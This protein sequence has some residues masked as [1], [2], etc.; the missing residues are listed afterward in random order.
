MKYFGVVNLRKYLVDTEEDK[1]K[2]D[3]TRVSTCIVIF[4]SEVVLSH[5]GRRETRLNSICV[6]LTF[7]RFIGNIPF[8]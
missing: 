6:A 5:Y 4:F 3:D 2:N 1:E 7:C 8:F